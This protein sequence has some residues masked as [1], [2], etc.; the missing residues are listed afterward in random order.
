MT[1]NSESGVPVPSTGKIFRRSL[2]PADHVAIAGEDDEVV[3]PLCGAAG[4]REVC[5]A[6]DP[7]YALPG[8]F[9]ILWCSRCEI[10]ST[11]PRLSVEDRQAYY[12]DEYDPYLEESSGRTHSRIHRLLLAAEARFGPA[13]TD[14]VPPGSLLDVGCGNGRYMAAMA[15]RGFSVQGVEMSL[16]A[17]EIV[18]RLGLPVVVGDFLRVSLP[19][20]SFDVVTMNHFLEHSSDP[21][22]SLERAYAV[23]KRRGHLVVGVPNFASWARSHFGSDWSDLEVPRHAFHFTP[24]GLVHLL[25]RYGFRTDAVRF[26]PTADAGSL[27]TS[28][29]VRYGKRYDPLVRR[30]YPALH[31][32]CYPVGLPLSLLRRSAWI[33]VFATK[34]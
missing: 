32:A 33:R 16:K 5:E 26:V 22:K 3:C 2:D 17:A 8:S 21:R 34:S 20:D 28:I 24:S 9:R 10:A 31:A 25:R 29:L 19:Q 11:H 1:Q 4:L 27:L 23:L 13:A 6:R 7:R 12:P 15:V 18:A 30:L 14:P